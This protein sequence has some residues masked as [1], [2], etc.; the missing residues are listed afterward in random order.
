MQTK[1][2]YM[3]VDRE[4]KL[5]DELLT[6]KTKVLSP[7]RGYQGDHLY[8]SG[9][10]EDKDAHDE[11]HYYHEMLLPAMEAMATLLNNADYME[12][13]RLP[14]MEVGEG[15]CQ[16]DGG[17][18]LYDFWLRKTTSYCMFG[19]DAERCPEH[20]DD[21]GYMV[22]PDDLCPPEC[23][24]EPKNKGLGPGTRTIYDVLIRS[25]PKLVVQ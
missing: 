25:S 18:S 24:F 16:S 5:L 12:F 6:I 3:N 15:A 9:Y 21:S 7:T 1:E 22:L 14:I 19:V 20:T 17:G 13:E 23:T 4:V 10:I 11:H 8:V 2:L